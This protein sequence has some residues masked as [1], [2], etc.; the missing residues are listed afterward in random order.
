MCTSATAHGDVHVLGIGEGKDVVH[1]ELRC[2]PLVAVVV[3]LS[4]D[5]KCL[6]GLYMCDL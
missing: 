3:H 6:F 2:A 4:R 1:A 5:D